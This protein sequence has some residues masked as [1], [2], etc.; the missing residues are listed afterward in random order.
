M[1]SI[2]ESEERD[3]EYLSSLFFLFTSCHTV[4]YV[5]SPSCKTLS[6][7]FVK[8]LQLLQKLKTALRQDGISLNSVGPKQEMLQKVLFSSQSTTSEDEKSCLEF[9]SET[10]DDLNIPSRSIWKEL[11]AKEE[12]MGSTCFVPGRNSPSLLFAFYA[13]QSPLNS[14]RSQFNDSDIVTYCESLERQVYMVL[15][16]AE[17]VNAS[18]S[19]S[20][21][22]FTY[23]PKKSVF[24]LRVSSS[25]PPLDNA[26]LRH[27]MLNSL[28]SQLRPPSLLQSAPS[29]NK[30]PLDHTLETSVTSLASFIDEKL[31]S[32]RTLS[33]Q[34]ILLLCDGT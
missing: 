13:P 9:L 6:L 30:T 14:E 8:D 22:L 24:V 31:N 17:L 2:Q 7:S 27:R 20:E 3:A 29:L 4:V 19:A 16:N 5:H 11:G 26:A 25:P 10:L 34:V 15:E 12:S 18:L 33:H 21:L 28:Y 32:L 23:Q 1:R